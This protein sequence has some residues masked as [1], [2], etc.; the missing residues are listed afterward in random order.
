MVLPLRL[1]HLMNAGND[2]FEFDRQGRLFDPAMRT[3]FSQMGGRGA[4]EP[5]ETLAALRLAANR[6]HAEMERWTE[7]HGLSESRLRVLMTLY[8]SPEHRRGPWGGAAMGGCCG[9][10]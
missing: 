9:G 2:G 3:R 1:R 8:Y 10:L 5:L 4:I 7:R 6:V